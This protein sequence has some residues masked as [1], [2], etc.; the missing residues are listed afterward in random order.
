MPSN[1]RWI[2]HVPSHKHN[3]LNCS[4]KMILNINRAS[5]ATA[6]FSP[7][8]RIFEA[9]GAGG[10]V[11]TD[12][13]DGIDQFFSPESEILCASSGQEVANRVSQV[14]K[15]Q[16]GLVGKAMR[17]RALREHT[18][19]LRAREV[20]TVLQ[21]LCSA[22]NIRERGLQTTINPAIEQTP[23]IGSCE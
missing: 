14:S 11:I 18:Y 16:A 13:W 15:F 17:E 20:H 9:A 23:L 2:G 7:P 1:V 6:G 21:Q 12:Q 4:A 22:S 10:C 5:M 8:T 19:E 3:V